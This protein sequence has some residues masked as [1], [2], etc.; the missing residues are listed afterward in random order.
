MV[1]TDG[2]ISDSKICFL[3]T[4]YLYVVSIGHRDHLDVLT[5]RHSEDLHNKVMSVLGQLYLKEVIHAAIVLDL[6]G[7]ISHAEL[8]LGHLVNVVGGNLLLTLV[9]F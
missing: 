6:V 4:S 8:A 3:T 5:D 2:Y 9:T 1:S 7:V